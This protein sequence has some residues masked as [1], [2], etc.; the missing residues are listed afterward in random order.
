MMPPK[1]S[2][3]SVCMMLQIPF[4][5]GLAPERLTGDRTTG[6]GGIIGCS[7]FGVGGSGA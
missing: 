4:G 1:G 6:G 2:R 3:A 5:S 7:R